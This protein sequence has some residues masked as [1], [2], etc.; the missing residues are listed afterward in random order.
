MQA[1]RRKTFGDASLLKP[2][3]G[4]L[5]PLS[6]AHWE[7]GTETASSVRWSEQR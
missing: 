5:Q 4:V 1:D 6:W 3:G 7:A 2:L